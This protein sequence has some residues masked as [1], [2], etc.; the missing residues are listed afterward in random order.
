MF[1]PPASDSRSEYQTLHDT[2]SSF[3]KPRV[4]ILFLGLSN[5]P[6]QIKKNDT[7]KLYGFGTIIEGVWWLSERIVLIVDLIGA[8]VDSCPVDM[9]D[10]AQ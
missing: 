1:C 10:A 3:N 4:P 7:H 8:D 2:E 6:A 5:R 9:A